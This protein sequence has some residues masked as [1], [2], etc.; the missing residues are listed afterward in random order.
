MCAGAILAGILKD[1]GVGALF[2]GAAPRALWIAPLGAMNFAGYE[3]AKKALNRADGQAGGALPGGPADR[4]TGGAPP[5]AG[6]S[7]PGPESAGPP[8]QL[9]DS[10]TTFSPPAQALAAASIPEELCR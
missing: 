8:A 1:E 10:A 9:G 2:K 3:L 5:K 6:A 4:Q 7:R